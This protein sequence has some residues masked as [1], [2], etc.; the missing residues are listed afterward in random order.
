[1]GHDIE[2]AGRKPAPLRRGV[3]DRHLDQVAAPVVRVADAVR[4]V[5]HARAD[6]DVLGARPLLGQGLGSLEGLPEV[7]RLRFVLFLPGGHRDGL[8]VRAEGE[9]ARPLEAGREPPCLAAGQR[10]KVDLRLLV[11]AT[12]AKEGQAATVG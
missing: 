5:F 1:M 4:A 12:D 3:A 10:Q 8:A 6:D 11:T 2:G 9:A 7:G